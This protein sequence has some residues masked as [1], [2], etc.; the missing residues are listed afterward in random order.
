MAVY[1][2]KL[3][4][5]DLIAQDAAYYGPCLSNLYKKATKASFGNQNYSNEEQKLHV[6]AFSQ[7]I[8]MED[9]IMSCELSSDINPVFKLS[10][11]RQK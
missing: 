4:N 6:I 7:L 5:V 1:H 9:Q 10:D 8:Y 11:L 3:Q 2:G